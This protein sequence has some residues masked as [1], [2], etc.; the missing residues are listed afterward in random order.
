MAGTMK[1]MVFHEPLRMQM[2]KLSIP[3]IGSDEVLV[4]VKACGICGSDISYYYGLSPLETATGRGPLI[5]GHE[6]S[7]EIVEL[8]SIPKQQGIF[9]VG[10]RVTV[11]PDASCNACT[12]CKKGQVNFCDNLAGLGVSKNGGFAE[13]VKSRHTGIF[14]LPDNVSYQQAAFS[15]PLACAMYSIRNLEVDLGV[16]C[17]IIGPG[18]IGLI[19]TQ[20]IKAAGAGTI[21]V[22]GTRDYRL[23]YAREMGADQRSVF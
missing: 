10:D 13:Y 6:L 7:G 1:A 12:Y 4:R 8:G 2:E 3:K 9:K 5:L 18:P 20:L 19:Q 23:E 21:V 22:V 17:V 14:M 16:F 15:E 11:D